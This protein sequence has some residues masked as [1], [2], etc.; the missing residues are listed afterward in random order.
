[1]SFGSNIN[2][3]VAIHVYNV[4][5]KL[6]SY[7]ATSNLTIHTINCKIPLKTL[8]SR[9]RVENLKGTCFLNCYQY[10]LYYEAILN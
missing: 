6:I 2:V 9:S 10:H 4:E 3:T 7:S 8:N 5:C 1:M